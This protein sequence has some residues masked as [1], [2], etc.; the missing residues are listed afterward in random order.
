MDSKTLVFKRTVKELSVEKT[1]KVLRI[2]EIWEFNL[3]SDLFNKI[4]K[5]PSVL[6][7]PYNELKSFAFKNLTLA[8]NCKF[9]NDSVHSSTNKLP[10]SGK[11]RISIAALVCLKFKDQVLLFIDHNH[12]KAKPF[13]GAYHFLKES[14]LKQN[15]LIT[16][17]NE[18]SMDLRFTV[19]AKNLKMIINW[20]KSRKEREL[21]PFRELKEELTEENQ[22]IT[23]ND[24]KEAISDLNES[25]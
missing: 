17:D 2:F 25:K 16:L 4:K 24:L 18:S 8:G 7:I 23:L 10:I 20:F 5:H 14:K 9:L 1:K 15:K 19:N 6:T 12:N 22:I 3:T 21:C 13:G 11:I